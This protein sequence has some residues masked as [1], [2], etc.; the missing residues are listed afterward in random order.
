MARKSNTEE[1]L[2]DAS[3]ERVIKYLEEPKATKKMACQMLNISYNT[4]RLDKL[5]ETFKNKKIKD[6][7][8]RAEKRGK[9]ASP[10]EISFIVVEYLSGTTIDSI[11]KSLFRGAT[12]IASVLETYAVPKRNTST[13]YFKPQLIPEEAIREDFRIGEVVYSARYDSLAKIVEE[14]K[15]KQGRAY[16]IWLS[17]EKWLEFASQPVWELASLQKLRDIG[18]KI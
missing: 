4:S 7:E 10:E 11:S 14:V 9:P 18:I 6:A 12:F 2:D 13:N 16:R 3:L 5:I 1:K 15:S 8:R 17:G